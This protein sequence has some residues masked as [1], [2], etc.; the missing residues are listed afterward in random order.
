[1]GMPGRAN[2]KGGDAADKR[3]TEANREQHQK[4]K[5]VARDPDVRGVTRKEG[6]R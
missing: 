5:D 2:N 1:M 3:R 4:D 6:R